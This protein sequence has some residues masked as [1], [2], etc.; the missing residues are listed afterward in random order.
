MSET[1]LAVILLRLDALERRLADQEA[2]IVE[3]RDQLRRPRI[4]GSDA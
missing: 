1:D 3:L 2:E 4:E